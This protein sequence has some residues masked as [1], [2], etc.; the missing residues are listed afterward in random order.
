VTLSIARHNT[1]N[2]SRSRFRPVQTISPQASSGMDSSVPIRR[3]RCMCS[4]QRDPPDP[5]SAQPCVRGTNGTGG[6]AQARS[7]SRASASL[8]LPKKGSASRHTSDVSPARLIGR[9]AVKPSCRRTP[10]NRCRFA[11]SVKLGNGQLDAAG[12]LARLRKIVL[13][14]ISDSVPFSAARRRW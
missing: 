5:P 10:K 11:F 8:Q 7:G 12:V 2:Y 14:R 6:Q 13:R 9:Y 1:H 4:D 3:P